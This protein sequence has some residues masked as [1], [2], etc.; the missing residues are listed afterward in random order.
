MRNE[1]K[2]ISEA[3][4]S[5]KIRLIIDMY[6]VMFMCMRTSYPNIKEFKKDVGLLN[7]LRNN[8]LSLNN[9]IKETWPR[10][11][12]DLWKDWYSRAIVEINYIL[13]NRYVP[14]LR[15]YKSKSNDES[16]IICLNDINFGVKTRCRHHFHDKCIVAWLNQ[17]TKCPICRTEILG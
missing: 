10:E 7:G 4:G 5:Y 8:L 9:Q 2:A 16:C 6:D 1:I 12:K 11:Y 15:P 13:I 17:S 3:R 14:Y